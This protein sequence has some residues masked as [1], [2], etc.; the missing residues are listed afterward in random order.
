M[1]FSSLTST[2]FSKLINTDISDQP[3][4]ISLLVD[5][6]IKIYAKYWDPSVAYRLF[7]S[8]LVEADSKAKLEGVWK[9]NDDGTYV[10]TEFGAL[11]IL[12]SANLVQSL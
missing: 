5:R 3:F 10:L 4:G 1:P 8:I 12:K 7:T 2:I 6:L 9:I 11:E